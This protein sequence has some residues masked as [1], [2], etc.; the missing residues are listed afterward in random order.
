MSSGDWRSFQEFNTK[1]MIQS[2]EMAK[3]AGKALDGNE[4]ELEQKEE[5]GLLS[6]PYHPDSKITLQEALAQGHV[7]LEDF[8]KQLRSGGNWTVSE[9]IQYYCPQGTFSEEFRKLGLL[10][11]SEEDERLGGLSEDDGKNA[12]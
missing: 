4:G 5:T 3:D 12:E 7:L 2:E 9:L 10:L 1:I 11:I 6:D 8:D